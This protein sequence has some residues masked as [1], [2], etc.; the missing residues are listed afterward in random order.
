MQVKELEQQLAKEEA[1]FEAAQK[2]AD[3]EQVGDDDYGPSAGSRLVLLLRFTCSDSCSRSDSF[4]C[5]QEEAAAAAA[6]A[7]KEAAEAAESRE[8]ARQEREEAIEMRRLSDE[9]RV[10]LRIIRNARIK[11]VVQSV[12]HSL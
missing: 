6:E 3:K 10:R 11:L 8:R 9:L 4:P 5:T 12:M 2:Q 7:A 1:E